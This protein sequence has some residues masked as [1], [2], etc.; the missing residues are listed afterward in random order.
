MATLHTI[1][2]KEYVC[3]PE[4]GVEHLKAKVDTGARTSALHV[5]NLREVESSEDGS[6]LLAFDIPLD[7]TGDRRVSSRA[8]YLRW[9]QVTDSGGHG[10]ERP[11]IETTLVLGP[12]RKTI[13]L[14][15][16]ARRGML[17]RMLLGRKTLE[18]TF[19]IDAGC[20]YLLG[21]APVKGSA[22]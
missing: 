11:V 3:L 13:L 22:R 5:E 9:I 21:K 15:L 8:R 7:R 19:L 10:E 12:V 14:T 17:F 20:K 16:T 4:L 6:G 18:D 1:G 2:W